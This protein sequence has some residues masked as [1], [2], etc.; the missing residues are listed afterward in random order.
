MKFAT[1]QLSDLV[2]HLQENPAGAAWLTALAVIA[3]C[4][5]IVYRLT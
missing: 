2:K 1:K 3:L 5:F 4:G